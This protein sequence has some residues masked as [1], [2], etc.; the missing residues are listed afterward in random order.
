MTKLKEKSAYRPTAVEKA[1]AW[2]VTA[3]AGIAVL[4]WAIRAWGAR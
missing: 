2:L 1:T 3:A 4:V